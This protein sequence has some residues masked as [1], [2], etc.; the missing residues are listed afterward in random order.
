MSTATSVY[1]GELRVENTHHKSGNKY[2]TDAPSDNNGKGEAFSPTDT[3]ATALASCMLT[4]MGIYAE[5]EGI[6]LK[7]TKA[8]VIKEMAA[9]PRR[10]SK[11]KIDLT[12]PKDYGVEVRKKLEQIAYSCPVFLS[13]HPDI[14]KE[15]SFNY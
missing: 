12:F 8:E 5:R 15:I 1:L 3:V 11:I 10:I 2:I 13:L 9:N 4:I 6:D 14:E 7:N